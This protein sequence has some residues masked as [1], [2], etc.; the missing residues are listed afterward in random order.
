MPPAFNLSQDQTLQFNTCRSPR[1]NR[2]LLDRVSSLTKVLRR[3]CFEP[4]GTTEHPHKLPEQIVKEHLTAS[5]RETHHST[6]SDGGVKLHFD[7]PVT[8]LNHGRLGM[9]NYTGKTQAVKRTC[10][11][12][13]RPNDRGK[14]K[15]PV[16]SPSRE[17]CG[18]FRPGRPARCPP[19]RGGGH[20]RAARRRCAL[21]P[22]QSVG[23]LRRCCSPGQHPSASFQ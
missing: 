21:H 22:G 16:R 23:W 12:G 20:R 2:S 14:R 13:C 15:S 4:L 5:L 7:R 8:M 17:R 1:G 11:G 18:V 6:D 3:L 9:R 10:H 19:D